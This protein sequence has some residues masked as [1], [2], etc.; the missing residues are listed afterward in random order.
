MKSTSGVISKRMHEARIAK[1][2]K[3][4]L[5]RPPPGLTVELGENRY[6]FLA[7]AEGP[8]GTWFEG[9]KFK[10]EI[11]LPEEYPMVPPKVLFRTK[12]FHPNVDK[13]GRICLDILKNKFS[14]AL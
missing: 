13:L 2:T 6:H 1:E 9:G 4:L 3:S 10:L 8:E 7:T 11:F 5:E 12:I 14:P